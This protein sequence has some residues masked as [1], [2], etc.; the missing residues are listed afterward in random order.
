MNAYILPLK[1]A[2]VK[3]DTPMPWVLVGGMGQRILN[4]L[5]NS[6][7]SFPGVERQP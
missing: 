3:G 1:S 2:L 7:G 5:A 6:V 4:E